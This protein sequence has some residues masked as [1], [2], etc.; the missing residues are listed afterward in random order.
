MRGVHFVSRGGA[1]VGIPGGLAAL[2]PPLWHA[3]ES[4]RGCDL[5]ILVVHGEQ[6]R[7]FPV[8]M[9]AELAE[10]CGA[11]TILVPNLGTRSRITGRRPEYWGPIVTWIGGTAEPSLRAAAPAADGSYV[12]GDPSVRS[13]GSGWGP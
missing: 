10:C 2:V 8:K 9:A 11:E 4:L 7:I 5:P 6:D 13:A 3:E 1:F 12:Q